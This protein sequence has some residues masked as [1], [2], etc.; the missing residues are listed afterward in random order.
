MLLTQNHKRW[1]FNAT[2]LLD[3]HIKG[4][5]IVFQL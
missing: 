2:E 5:R 3:I 4:T 1:N